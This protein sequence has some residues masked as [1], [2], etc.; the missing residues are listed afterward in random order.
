MFQMQ[1]RFTGDQSTEQSIVF[2]WTWA[3]VIVSIV[4]GDLENAF[5]MGGSPCFLLEP[6]K[7]IFPILWQLSDVGWHFLSRLSWSLS[8]P[9]PLFLLLPFP[10]AFPL[11]FPLELPLAFCFTNSSAACPMYFSHFFLACFSTDSVTLSSGMWVAVGY[12]SNF[13]S[14]KNW[15]LTFPSIS[16]G[17]YMIHHM[18]LVGLLP[19]GDLMQCQ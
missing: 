18:L 17:R 10:L 6:L 16:Q 7:L 5:G 4:A 19:R 1:M 14:R 15:Q 13:N 8:S 9:F 2:A 11:A 12:F 3:A